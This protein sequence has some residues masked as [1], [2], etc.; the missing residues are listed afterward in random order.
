MMVYNRCIGWHIIRCFDIPK[1]LVD[2]F[3][4]WFSFIYREQPIFGHE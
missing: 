1:V 3:G 4:E 2:V